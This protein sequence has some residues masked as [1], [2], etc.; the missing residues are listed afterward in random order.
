V[1]QRDVPLDNSVPDGTQDRFSLFCFVLFVLFFKHKLLFA[2]LPGK[3]S[4]KVTEQE[5]DYSQISIR[6]QMAELLTMTICFL[7][8]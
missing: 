1:L 3:L 2:V 7:L 8:L 6:S 5:A 4:L